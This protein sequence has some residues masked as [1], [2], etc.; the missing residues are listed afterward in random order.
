[1]TTRT[2]TFFDLVHPSLDEVEA[3]MRERVGESHPALESAIDHLLSSGGKRVRPTVVLLTAAM[4][5]ANRQHSVTLAAAIEML[6]TATLVHDDLIDGA[7]LRRGTPTLN[8]Q[9]T[10][11][12]TVLTG[13]YLFAR[14]AFLCSQ[15]GSLVVMEMF[16][17]ALMTIVGGEIN[18]LFRT[19]SG[20]LRQDY[21]NRIYAKTASLFELSTE[22]AAVLS[23]APA[24]QT[25]Q[26]KA[27]GY[28]LGVAFQI[29]DDVL[30]F[31]GNQ[32]EVGKPVASDLRQGLLTLPA[33]LA[34]DGR[35]VADDFIEAILERRLD[36]AV[37]ED[38][39][40][41]VRTSDAIARSLDEAR[42][43]ARQAQDA[44]GALPACQERDAL[45]DL[46]AYIVQR[47]L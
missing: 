7:L 32:Q 4:F 45:S 40:W 24:T 44:L 23:G 30:D 1:M 15:T 2:A 6:H 22:A 27:V 19:R 20:D 37:L 39:I 10:P 5:G 34:L 41:Q 42:A 25:A 13:D 12:A 28:N 35:P 3:R 47:T 14:A 43:Y 38:L 36:P 29:V 46:A 17:R 16:A 18:Q 9:W 11:A 31:V 26:A 8:A 33:L 21:F